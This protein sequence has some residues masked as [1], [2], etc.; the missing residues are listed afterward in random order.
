MN[1]KRFVYIDKNVNENF[2]NFLS[3]NN[4]I[5]NKTILVKPPATMR[6]QLNK[7]SEHVKHL[8]EEIGDISK[9]MVEQENYFLYDNSNM[10]EGAFYSELN[11]KNL[12]LRLISYFSNQKRA[13]A[14]L[15]TTQKNI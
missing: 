11:K 4:G 7:T 3:S 12:K 8:V 1:L 10:I 5:F 9:Y 2:S 6:T 15:I 14:R 13:V